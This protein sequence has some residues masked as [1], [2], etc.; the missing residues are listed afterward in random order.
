[1]KLRYIIASLVL[2]S[3]VFASCDD[4]ISVPNT[5]NKGKEKPTVAT[6]LKDS[7]DVEFTLTFTVS[8]DVA[9]FG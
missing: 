8:E 3:L 2:G 9:S 7:T 4:G 5:A 1:M 6:E